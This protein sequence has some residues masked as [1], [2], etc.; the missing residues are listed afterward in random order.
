MPRDL[1]DEVDLS[2]HIHP[3]GRHVDV[4]ASVGVAERETEAVE[5]A[6]H[7][8]VGD[9]RSQH[10][11]NP[12]ATKLECRRVVGR[13]TAVHHRT[14]RTPGSDEF[15]ERTRPL[16]GCLRQLR[17]AAALEPHARFRLEAECAAGSPDRQRIEVR[18]LEEDGLRCGPDFR[19]C[20]AHHAGN[21]NRAVG[22]GDDQ[23]VGAQFPVLAV[24]R[25]QDFVLPRPPDDDASAAERGKVERVHGLTQF[26]QHVVGDVHDVADGADAG[27]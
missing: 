25:A 2:N 12:S 14:A 9:R 1:F 13:G 8:A 26:Q 17:I 15:D 23:H 19:V 16:H 18:A 6:L 11:L 20:A 10:G 22:I 27:G 7:V 4:P 3:P 5:D 21:R 24:Q